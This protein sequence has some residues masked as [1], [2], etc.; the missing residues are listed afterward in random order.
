[1]NSVVQSTSQAYAASNGGASPNSYAG[2]S[3]GSA[4]SNG[5]GAKASSSL[6]TKTVQ[7]T[8]QCAYGSKINVAI[9]YKTEGCLTVKKEFTIVFACNDVDRMES[10]AAAC[11]SACGNRACDER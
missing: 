3:G 4:S 2:S 10:A 8:H 6:P 11:Q 7:F 5:N 1:M 9:P